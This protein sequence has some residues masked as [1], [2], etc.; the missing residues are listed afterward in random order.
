MRSG[1]VVARARLAPRRSPPA[2]ILSP[3]TYSMF[4]RMKV[5]LLATVVV[6]FCPEVGEPLSIP[7]MHSFVSTADAVVGRPL[8]PVIA[9]ALPADGTRSIGR[10]A[11]GDGTPASFSTKGCWGSQARPVSTMGKHGAEIVSPSQ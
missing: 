10:H 5:M 6:G 2:S 9:T 3:S 11:R 7:G 4:K 8:T 1:T